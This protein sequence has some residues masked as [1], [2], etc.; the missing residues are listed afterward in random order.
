M[1]QRVLYLVFGVLAVLI[2]VT[3]GVWIIYNL[4]VERQP[5]FNEPVDPRSY[6][7]PLV[8]VGV[9]IGMIVK[10]VKSTGTGTNAG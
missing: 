2:G 9:G 5:E 6:L 8:M 3:I 4:L 1:L 10:A 7:F